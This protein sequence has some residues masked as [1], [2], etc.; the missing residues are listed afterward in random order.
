[1]SSTD[2]IQAVCRRPAGGPDTDR[3]L[4]HT[5]DMAPAGP[6]HP[7]RTLDAMTRRTRLV[8]TLTGLLAAAAGCSAG[9]DEPRTPPG[10]P[11]AGPTR[12]ILLGD[13]VAAG[14]ALPLTEA[15]AAAGVEFHSMASDGGGTVVGP[16]SEQLW[17]TLPD[18]LA[19]ARPST[20][21]YQI[22]TYDWG[23]EKE[24]R[25]AYRK[26]ATTVSG[27]GA[28]LVFVTMPP[29]KPDDFYRPHMADLNHAAD[30]ARSVGAGTVVLDAGEVWGETYQRSRDGVVDR[31]SDGIHT[32][33]QGAARFTSW[34]LG[35]LTK[36]YPGF[37]P[38]AAADWANTG[39][40]G[41][42]RFI[43]C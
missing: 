17:K 4:R 2:A 26:L 9:P 16:V 32:C 41:D 13:S 33:P 5:C 43:G 3:R 19:T 20:V 38:P 31:S 8:L 15:F 18:S 27:A 21:I 35:E 6:G 24:Q 36:L 10:P 1:M 40:S 42:K 14:Q 28:R 34:L 23:S 11:A 29:I 7:R 37:R 22:T 39:W 25:A 30:A 12:V